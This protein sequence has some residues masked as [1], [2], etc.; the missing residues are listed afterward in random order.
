MKFYTPHKRAWLVTQVGIPT[1]PKQST[2]S[3]KLWARMN[4]ATHQTHFLVLAEYPDKA[5]YAAG[6]AMT[7]YTDSADEIWNNPHNPDFTY[8]DA[9]ATNPP[10]ALSDTS[11][12]VHID[13]IYTPYEDPLGVRYLLRLAV[14]LDEGE[15]NGS[16]HDSIIVGL[17]RL[18]PH[19][20]IECAVNKMIGEHPNF[21]NS[22]DSHVDYLPEIVRE[23]NSIASFE[24]M[25]QGHVVPEARLSLSAFLRITPE[26]LLMRLPDRMYF[27]ALRNSWGERDWR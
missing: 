27:S 4:T 24:D 25:A 18:D 12:L 22:Y 8:T 9:L 23:S 11:Y 16:M 20:A 2:Y 6:H 19:Q 7:F 13:E 10:N 26:G 21:F 3:D 14:L 1:Q 17:D 15:N 5:A